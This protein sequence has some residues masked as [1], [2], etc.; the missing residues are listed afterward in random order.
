MSKWPNGWQRVG[1]D[2]AGGALRSPLGATK[3]E[4][5][6]VIVCVSLFLLAIIQLFGG[7]LVNVLNRG[8]D[9]L[10]VAVEGESSEEMASAATRGSGSERGSST[11]R[12]GETQGGATVGRSGGLSGGSDRA[13]AS[14][15]QGLSPGGVVRSQAPRDEVEAAPGSIGG[16][17]PVVW[18]IA[19]L[20]F[21]LLGYVVFGEKE[22]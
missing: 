12:S 13:G 22:G 21:L 16:I 18:V 19:L 4:Y 3:V 8:L 15:A 7:G 9:M 6:V 11:T 1:E 17:N 2:W 20:L 5:L 14:D 10:E